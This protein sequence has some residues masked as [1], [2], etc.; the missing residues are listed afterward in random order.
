MRI[1]Y[2]RTTKENAALIVRDGFRLDTRFLC[3]QPDGTM[4]LG[5]VYGV[6][7][8]DR[9]LYWRGRDDSALLEVTIYA[10]DGFMDQ[11]EWKGEPR[12]S[13]VL[14]LTGRPQSADHLNPFDVARRAA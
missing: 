8:S 2:H 1:F 3:R 14:R 10:S 6:W 9:P 13:R 5:K 4:A 7:L 11:Y 12:L